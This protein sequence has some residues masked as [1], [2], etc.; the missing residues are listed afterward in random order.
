[1]L[2]LA[3]PGKDNS[4]YLIRGEDTASI[5]TSL[6]PDEL[7]VEKALELLS[8]PKGGRDLGTDPATGLTVYAKTGRF[9]PYVQLGD[10]DDD[11]ASKPKMA[12]LFS[13]MTVDHV[14]LDDALEL[15]SLPRVVGIDP[16]DGAEITAANGRYGPYVQ[17]VDADGKKDSRSLTNE[18]QLLTVTLDDALA[19]F[20]QPK[21]R[22]GQV[23]KP[24]L[25]QLG[26]DRVSGKAMVVK[27]GRFG[28][29]VTDGETNASLRKSDDVETITD[30]RAS[31]LLADRR[32][33]GP[34]K[35]AARKTTRKS[36]KKA[37]AKKTAAKKT[38]ARKAGAKKTAAKKAAA[39]SARAVTPAS[40]AQAGTVPA[41]PGDPPF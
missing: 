40:V 33:R 23:A 1:V 7:T 22:K 37:G 38:A 2:I 6:P 30:E 29:Y 17:K 20:A 3:K 25:R 32:E 36:T 14:G 16:T 26:E 11:G 28:P 10:Y 4:P 21:L 39:R 24:P 27:D 18:E 8:A 31:E 35:K 13:T 34:A 41:G 15:L 5:P 19:I 9:G 12:S